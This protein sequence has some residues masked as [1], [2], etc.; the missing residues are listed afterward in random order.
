LSVLVKGRCAVLAGAVVVLVAGCAAEGVRRDDDGT[1][2]IEC[3]GGYHDWSICY[4]RAETACRSAG[5]EI[6]SQV[7]NE[8]GEGVGTRD[9]ST[10]GSEVWRTMVVRCR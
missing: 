5:Y 2:T 7:S 4:S 6:L 1:V 3:G 10:R 9:W 8:G